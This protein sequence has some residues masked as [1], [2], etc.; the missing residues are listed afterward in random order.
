VRSAIAGI[1]VATAIA[2]ANVIARTLNPFEKV[3]RFGLRVGWDTEA[4]SRSRSS[5][6]VSG[7]VLTGST[8]PC[9]VDASR[10]WWTD[11]KGRVGFRSLSERK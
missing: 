10:F 7:C 2:A 3:E 1:D 4:R 6:R 11:V 8:E 5:R 9:D